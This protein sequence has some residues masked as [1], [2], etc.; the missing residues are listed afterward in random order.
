MSK[1]NAL[2]C[3][4][5]GYNEPGIA[6]YE[7]LLACYGRD[8]EAYRDLR[9]SFV[10]LDGQK[11]DYCGLLNIAWQHAHPGHPLPP[12]QEFRSG[13]IPNLAAAYLTNLLRRQYKAEYINLFQSGKG[14]LAAL[15]DAGT[16]LVAITTTFYVL[17]QPVIEMVR[18]ARERSKTVKIVVGGPLVNNHRRRGSSEEFFLALDEIGADFYVVDA[19]GET[20]LRRLVECLKTGGLIEAIPN[21]VYRR[22]GRLIM[23][24]AQPEDNSLDDN[25]I[26]WTRLADHRLGPTL[27]MRTARSCAFNC[28][29]CAYPARAGPLRLASINTVEQELESMRALGNVRQVVFIDD[30]FNVPLKRFK[31]LC[32]KII[33]LDLKFEWYSYFRCSNADEEAVELAARSGCKGVFLGVESGSDEVLK[34]MNKAAAV[35]QYLRGIRWLKQNGILTFGSFIAGFPGETEATFQQTVDFIRTSAL[36]YYRIQLWYCEPGTPVVN[37]RERWG[38]TGDGFRWKHAT[39]TSREGMRLIEKAFLEISESLWMPQWSFDFWIIPYLA[40]RGISHDVFR[41]F[42]AAANRLLALGFEPPTEARSERQAE[43]IKLLGE[44]VCGLQAP[45]NPEGKA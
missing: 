4:V 1:E 45:L 44:S 17:N 8:S 43:L 28:A 6:T 11:L 37:Q 19:Q 10:D 39:M 5:I 34:Y 35:E 42:M 18:F 40:G 26:D 14:R 31:D 25:F 20:T 38:I 12:G 13:D 7:R 21:L 16:L 30:T 23:T 32:N 22:G 15:L 3:V 24:L 27:Q 36:D 9:L 2:D 29:F 33:E 41:R